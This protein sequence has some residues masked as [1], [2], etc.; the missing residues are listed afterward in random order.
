MCRFSAP[1]LMV[2]GLQA[3]QYFKAYLSEGFTIDQSKPD[4]DL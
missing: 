3:G 4:A 1:V 2:A